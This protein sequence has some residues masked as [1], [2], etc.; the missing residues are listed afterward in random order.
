[1]R[2]HLRI[3]SV[4]DFLRYAWG[5]LMVN[6]YEGTNIP[7]YGGEEVCELHLCKPHHQS[8]ESTFVS[9]SANCCCTRSAAEH[10]GCSPVYLLPGAP[11]LFA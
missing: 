1:M 7:I 6:Q 2:G 10:T 4:Q 11:L 3:V 9:C 5:A 8:F